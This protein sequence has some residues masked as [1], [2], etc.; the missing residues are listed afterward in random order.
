MRKATSFLTNSDEIKKRLANKFCRCLGKRKHMPIQGNDKKK[1]LSA[2]SA[3][4]PDEL[5]REVAAATVT[6]AE[7]MAL[8]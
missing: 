1:K 8:T 7:R 4:Y 6:I 3:I 2:W 5:C